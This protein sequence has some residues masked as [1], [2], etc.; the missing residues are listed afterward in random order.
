LV[1]DGVHEAKMRNLMGK[2]KFFYLFLAKA[3][4][5]KEILLPLQSVS[6]RDE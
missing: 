3:L 6:S 1:L 4:G 2:N 5:K